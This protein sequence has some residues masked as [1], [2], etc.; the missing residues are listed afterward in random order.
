MG[1]SP[2]E[3]C[4]SRLSANGDLVNWRRAASQDRGQ[5]SGYG[6]TKS[7]IPKPCAVVLGSIETAIEMSVPYCRVGV[8]GS[9]GLEVGDRFVNFPL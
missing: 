8:P 1:Y 7:S 4:Y 2:N 9:S 3:T 5:R 6:V